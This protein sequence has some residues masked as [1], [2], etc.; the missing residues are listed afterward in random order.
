MP[1]GGAPRTQPAPRAYVH[2]ELV[3]LGQACA[4]AYHVLIEGPK[5]TRD[6]EEARRHIAIALSRVATLYRAA[7]GAFAPLSEV[8]IRSSL[9]A[10]APDL[11]GLYIRRGTLLAAV[12]TL[13][14]VRMP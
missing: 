1:D 7:D 2:E 6:I 13:K 12:E 5:A 11:R 3:P 9:F 4:A 8:E 14:T 10:G